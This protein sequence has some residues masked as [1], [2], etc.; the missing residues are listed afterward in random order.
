MLLRVL[1]LQNIGSQ[2]VSFSLMFILRKLIQ[3]NY[4][5]L[6]NQKKLI[7]ILQVKLFLSCISK[8]IL[9]KGKE[10]TE[11]VLKMVSETQVS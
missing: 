7:L 3:N 2:T 5:F 6:R 11:V 10:L 9:K 8:K 4:V 1:N